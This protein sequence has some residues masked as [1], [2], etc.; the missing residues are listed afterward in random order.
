MFPWPPVW[1]PIPS[2]F[3][4][5][6]EKF[7]AGIS[8]NLTSHAKP[9][10]PARSGEK[11][12]DALS[13]SSKPTGGKKVAT[14]A[15]AKSPVAKNPV[16]KNPV[17]KKPVAKKPVAKKP[18]K[19]APPPPPPPPPPPY[20]FEYEGRPTI[21]GRELLSVGIFLHSAAQVMK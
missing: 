15:P 8:T 14:A 9:T 12:S 13:L 21:G 5:A 11:A 10:T 17:A 2:N 1:R 19:P 20:K 4:N 16:A 18:A 7:Q 6:P 3:R